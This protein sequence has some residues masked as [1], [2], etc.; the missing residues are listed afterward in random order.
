MWSKGTISCPKTGEI[1]SYCVKHY[2]EGSHFGIGGD[3]RISKLEIRKNGKVLFNYDR[4][5]DYDS[6]DESG[7]A[8]YKIILAKY[9]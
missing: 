2:E 9:N 8:I 5:A 7:H 3:G 4:G 1:Y 6:L